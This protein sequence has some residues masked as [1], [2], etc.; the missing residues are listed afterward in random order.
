MRDIIFTAAF[1]GM[2]PAALR[3]G[4]VGTMLWA[5]V[6][7]IAP[8]QYLYG[9]ARGL[10]FN[11]IVVAVAVL[12]LVLDRARRPKF[13]ADTHVKLLLFFLA[14][15]LA[16]YFFGITDTRRG[17][18]LAD[19]LAKAVALCLFVVATVR[20]RLHIHS[21]LLA[22]CMGMAIHGAIEAAKFLAS[23]GGHILQGPAT[24]GDNNHFGLAILMVIPPLAYLFRYSAAPLVRVALGLALAGNVV[25][26]I[27]S[28]SRGALIGLIAVGGAMFLRSRNKL[29]TMIV[30]IIL[31]GI[32]LTIA[33]DRWFDRM[34]TISSAETDGSF[35]G[36]V[37]SWKMNLLVALDR[38]LLGGGFSAMEDFNAWSIYLREFSA[39]DFIRTGMPTRPLAA[40]SIYFQVLGDTGF[41]G[42]ALFVGL[43]YLGFRNVRVI[44]RLTKDRPDLEWARDVGRFLRFTLIAY[45]V[46]GAAL[47]LAYFEFYY[48]VLTLISVT[49]RNVE[50][51]VGKPVGAG[52]A[53]LQAASGPRPGFAPGMARDGRAEPLPTPR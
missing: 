10:P 23:G 8:N 39:L 31:G 33:P 50:M 32:G 48:L 53:M 24:I 46:S 9:F 4:H 40:H 11:K 6:A 35:M 25:G 3:F 16:S 52:L 14:I 18:D 45:A 2:L 20:E 21:V 22:I 41:I 44:A 36:R 7:M 12:A 42:F 30:I 47:S 38:P 49:R 29:R 17:D 15:G 26:V 43:L 1:L 19:R 27:A 28:N 51:A 37:A 13:Y 5:W 34:S